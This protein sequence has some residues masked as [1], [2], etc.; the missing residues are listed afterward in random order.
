MKNIQVF[1]L[2]SETGFNVEV[3]SLGGIISKIM[4]KN[5]HGERENIV[6]TYENIEDYRENALFLGCIT[7]PVAGRTKNG[8][9]KVDSMEMKLDTSCH[10]NS[11][12]SCQD[13]LHL[14]DWI[15]RSQSKSHVTLSTKSEKYGSVIDYQVTYRVRNES[16][17]METIVSTSNPL[18]FSITNHS[19]FNLTGTENTS[20][21]KHRL[22]L[23]CSHVALLDDESLPTSLIDI[24]K[25]DF[26]YS[27]EQ[28]VDSFKSG[29][30]HP[31]KIV[32]SK[33]A[34]VLKDPISR[35]MMLVRTSHPYVVVYSGNFLDSFTSKSGKRFSK[36][37]GICFETQ[38]LPNVPNSKL[39]K[40]DLVLPDAPYRHTTEYEFSIY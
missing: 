34:A 2:F 12:H 17:F 3:L 36:H 27:T 30:D 32:D 14:I 9:I 33:T 21:D 15:P 10:P 8:S 40:V 18:Y 19:Y 22:Y 23:N 13:G 6:L 4:A 25:S 39:D 35:R 5:L 28:Y 1:Q 11:L 16:L 20:I 29:I 24:K 26:D 7:G 31:F 37:A 38:D